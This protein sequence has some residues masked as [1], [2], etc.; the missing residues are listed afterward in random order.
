MFVS[1]FLITLFTPLNVFA[2]QNDDGIKVIA[3]IEAPAE[4]GNVVSVS[5]TPSAYRYNAYSFKVK[6]R[7]VKIR[8]IEVNNTTST[9]TIPRTAANASIVSYDA[10][11]NEVSNL[12]R[13]CAYEIWTVNM[14]VNPGDYYA[15]SRDNVSWESLE[16][17]KE[18]SVTLSTDR[19]DVKSLTPASETAAVGEKV[20]VAVVTGVDVLKVQILVDNQTVGEKTF[21]VQSYGTLGDDSCTFNVYA[22]IRSAGTHTLKVR[23][24]TADGWETVDTVTATVTA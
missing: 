22:A 4:S 7:A 3:R 21:N 20:N 5:Y 13:N 16:A 15:V 8:L 19:K 1:V 14:S 9:I 12:S 6:G 18:F 10:D 17:A 24:R 23:I 11:G 2:V